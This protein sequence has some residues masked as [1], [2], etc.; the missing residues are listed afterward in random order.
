MNEHYQSNSK[1]LDDH[2]MTRLIHELGHDM[3]QRTRIKLGD[4]NPEQYR[5]I[6]SMY[7]QVQ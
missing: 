7:Q 2:F 3:T 4:T 5:E 1:L 6:E